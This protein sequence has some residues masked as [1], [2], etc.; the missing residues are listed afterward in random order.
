MLAVIDEALEDFLANLAASSRDLP[1]EEL[2]DLDRVVERKLYDI[3][4]AD[5][6]TVTDGSDDG[7][8]YARGFVVAMGRDF[9][10]G[11]LRDPRLAVL[12]AWCEE[13]CYFFAHLHDERYGTCRKPARESPASRAR[14][15]PA[16]PPDPRTDHAAPAPVHVSG[17]GW[18]RRGGRL[19]NG[20]V[21]K[22]EL[23]GVKRAPETRSG[24]DIVETEGGS[25]TDGAGGRARPLRGLRVVELSSYVATPLCGMTL[26]QL[27]ADVIRVEPVGGAVDRTRWP[28][29]ASGTSLYW[30]GL[31]KGKRAI[32]VDLSREEGRRLVADLVVRAGIVVS[33]ADRFRELSYAA[34]RA[35]RPDVIHVLLTGRRD[36]EAAVDYTVQAATGFPS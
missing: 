7:F 30:S 2:T 14:T 28:L 8:L 1:A 33:N 36:G 16:G 17:N 3:D 18:V 4:R 24:D 27:G 23:C 34:L 25:V 21:L 19:A 11:V 35:R 12:D 29:A 10:A 15:P 6:Q 13:M 22:A 26:A 32:E 31:N 20:N 9:Y 5:I